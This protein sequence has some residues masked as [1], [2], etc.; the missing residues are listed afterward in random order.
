MRQKRVY[1][2]SGPNGAG[3]TTFA[4]VF[5]K[6]YAK[7]YEFVNADLIATGLSPFSP[8]K[9][10]LKAGKILLAQIKEFS[11]KGISFAF[12]TT[13]S[14]KGYQKLL[15][16]LKDMGYEIDIFFL[17]ISSIDIAVM[18]VKSRVLSGG[19]NV[20]VSDIKRRFRRSLYNFVTIYSKLADRWYL[21]NNSDCLPIIVAAR[22]NGRVKVFDKLLFEKIQ[23]QVGVK[24]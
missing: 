24:L 14:G 11:Q 15:S 19:H 18:R 16:D 5:L 13:F 20:P 2:I 3:K 17:W 4:K 10:S 9:V 7:C 21:F 8:Q 6:D 1:I 23:R 22:Q 12:E